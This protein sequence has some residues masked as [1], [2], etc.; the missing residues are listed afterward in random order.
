MGIVKKKAQV[1][2]KADKIFTPTQNRIFSM[3]RDVLLKHAALINLK[4]SSL[5]AEERRLIVN[6][7][8]FGLMKGTIALK[9]IQDA[10]LEIAKYM[11]E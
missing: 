9:E 4:V 7:V 1:I 3:D 2:K 8:E 5:S 11:R 6:R 10:T